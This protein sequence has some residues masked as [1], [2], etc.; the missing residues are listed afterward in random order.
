[1]PAPAPPVF[2]PVSLAPVLALPVPP[3]SESRHRQCRRHQRSAVRARTASRPDVSRWFSSAAA[4]CQSARMWTRALQL[5]RVL[6]RRQ[7]REVR[8]PDNRAVA[9]PVAI[10]PEPIGPILT[11]STRRPSPDACGGSVLGCTLLHV[12]PLPCSQN[13]RNSAFH[14]KRDCSSK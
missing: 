7:T 14:G 10:Q 6:R 9:P 8:H 5:H 3:P 2:V 12:R 13:W 4:S 11:S 1:M